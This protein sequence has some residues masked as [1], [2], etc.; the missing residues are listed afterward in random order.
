MDV[1]I[2][3]DDPLAYK[4]VAMNCDHRLDTDASRF[5]MALQSF[6]SGFNLLINGSSGS[7]KTNL[8]VSLLKSRPDHKKGPGAG[9]AG[10]GPRGILAEVG[11]RGGPTR[12]QLAGHIE[13]PPRPSTSSLPSRKRAR[14]RSKQNLIQRH[15]S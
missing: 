6:V 7:G 3:G 13:A 4:K 8:L 2:V 1:K 14:R 15:R 12:E 11:R 9:S 5:P 10:R